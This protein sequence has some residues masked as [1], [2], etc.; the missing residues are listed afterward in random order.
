MIPDPWAELRRTDIA[1]I[2]WDIPE[3]GRYY[4]RERVI[5]I[6]R[7]LLLVE[8]RAV[9]WHELVHARRGDEV[10][11]P[12]TDA[13]VD[14]EAARRAMPTNDLVEAFRGARSYA[15]VADTLKTTVRL[16]RVRLETLHPAERAALIRLR[17]K[18]EEVA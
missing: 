9:L 18:L 8:E 4:H 12:K 1:L 14:R 17:D 3:L 2:R 10:C 7:G 15:E 16:L 11:T 13:S 5:V 6:R